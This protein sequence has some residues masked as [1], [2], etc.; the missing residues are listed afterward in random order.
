MATLKGVIELV[1]DIKPNAFSD[2][3]KTQWLNE[4][5][6][7][8]Q[9]E[10][11]LLDVA[12]CIS[13]SYE[14]DKDAVLLVQP[15]H[16]K[17]YWTYLV[18]MID[19]ANGEYNRYQDTVQM[20]NAFFGEY[21]RWYARTYRPA[22][23]GPVMHGY[24]LSAY[25]IAVKHGYE[26]TEAQW[27][28]TLKGEQG[29]AGKSFEILGYYG[30]LAELEAGVPAP[31]PGAVYGVGTSA[32]YDIYVWD[33]VN[34]AWINNG[35]IQGPRGEKGDTGAPGPQGPQGEKGEKGEQGPEGPAGPQGETGSQGPQGQKGDKGD[36]GVKGDQGDAGYTPVKGIDYFDGQDGAPGAD[37]ITPH[38]GQNG[39]WF[40][41]DI[42]TS[43]KAEGQDGKDGDP[44]QIVNDLTTGGAD[45]ALSAEQGKVLNGQLPKPYELLETVTLVEAVELVERTK[46]P[47]NT[48]YALK[49]ALVDISTPSVAGTGTVAFVFMSGTTYLG[50]VSLRSAITENGAISSGE[51]FLRHGRWNEEVAAAGANT[52]TGTI[53]TYRSPTLLEASY[54]VI[55]RIR[56]V[57]ATPNVPLPVGTVIN[58]YGV[59][60]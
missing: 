38:I 23:G 21:M 19:F 40:V 46:E 39:N 47:D 54:P 41:G 9:T 42:D 25:S 26:G 2:A 51:M 17:V 24:Y 13:Y 31:G 44:L 35:T 56:L 12:A 30:S 6:G 20:Y 37:G 36:P 3:V 5:E 32:P 53:Y 7:V 22:D 28:E 58:I 43:I 1:D 57:A 15:P 14:R 10:V 52:G 4:C 49:A 11:M 8:I 33:A 16:D 45:K 34:G 18:A 27:L 59:R 55:D 60:A 50:F 29:P 48:P